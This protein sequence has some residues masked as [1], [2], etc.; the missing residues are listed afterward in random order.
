MFSCTRTFLLILWHWLVFGVHS[1]SS[2]LKIRTWDWVFFWSKQKE[3]VCFFMEKGPAFRSQPNAHVT[4]FLL[5]SLPLMLHF[6]N[7]TVIPEKTSKVLW[8]LSCLCL[9]FF[10]LK[11]MQKAN[12]EIMGIHRFQ[13]QLAYFFLLLFL[14]HHYCCFSCQ[15]RRWFWLIEL[16][17]NLNGRWYIFG[18]GK[19][20]RSS[21]GQG[22][23]DVSEQLCASAG[24][25]RPEQGANQWD[26]PEPW[27]EDP[28]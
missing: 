4:V 16:K 23:A 26:Q 18:H 5:C 7:Q 1:D 15:G 12:E 27:V 8:F 6:P 22:F 19:W 3:K 20:N 21:R 13:N 24:H 10:H 11:V 28:W 14:F 9:D 2:V 17:C 25:F